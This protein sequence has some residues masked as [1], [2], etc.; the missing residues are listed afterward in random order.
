MRIL[1]DTEN[2]ALFKEAA[3]LRE[4]IKTSLHAKSRNILYGEDCEA[5]KDRKRCWLCLLRRI[6]K[7]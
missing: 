5:V 2:K 6:E 3:Q 1:N 7:D 4:E